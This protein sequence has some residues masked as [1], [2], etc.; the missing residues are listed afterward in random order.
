MRDIEARRQRL[1]APE[2][3]DIRTRVPDREVAAARN[4]RF[5]TA[6]RG[7]DR[8]EVHRYMTRINTMLAELQITQAPETAVKIALEE[9]SREQ[10]SVIEEAHKSAEEITARSRSRADDRIREATVEAEKLR[11]AAIQ[12]TREMREAAERDAHEIRDAA[13]SRVREIEAQIDGML[14]G[15]TRVLAELRDLASSLDGVV[16]AKGGDPAALAEAEPA[17]VD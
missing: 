1:K 16:E 7:Y 17:Q 9:V 2:G 8:D 14:E 3:A 11:D 15:R 12:E 13:E 6:I 5:S 10:R 4:V